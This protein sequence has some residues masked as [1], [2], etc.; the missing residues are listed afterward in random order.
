[1]NKYLRKEWIITIHAPTITTNKF[2]L[3][4]RAKRSNQMNAK[5]INYFKF[6][7]LLSL[8]LSLAIVES[9]ACS[10][11]LELDLII[12]SMMCF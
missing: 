11:I 8:P 3:L 2:E 5:M 10:L 1:M 4:K 9:I 12:D 7:F 6:M